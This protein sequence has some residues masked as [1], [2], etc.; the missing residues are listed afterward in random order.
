MDTILRPKSLN[1]VNTMII[2]KLSIYEMP[3]KFSCKT[4]TT[5]RGTIFDRFD[6]YSDVT[7]GGKCWNKW[8][9]ATVFV[10]LKDEKYILMS[11]Y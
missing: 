2:E 4:K 10:A 3:L 7:Q 8:A 9:D 6:G 1:Y 11:I 5:S